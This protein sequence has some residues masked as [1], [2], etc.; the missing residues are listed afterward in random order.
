[1]NLGRD[2]LVSFSNER[3]LKN[4]LDRPNLGRD[5]SQMGNFFQIRKEHFRPLLSGVL[6]GR[7]N[8]GQTGVRTRDSLNLVRVR[9]RYA[10][11]PKPSAPT[12]LPYVVEIL[13]LVMTGTCLFD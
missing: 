5:T 7:E 3:R 9:C 8:T 6:V 10:T 11:R 1:M 13:T 2:Q 12:V 4:S